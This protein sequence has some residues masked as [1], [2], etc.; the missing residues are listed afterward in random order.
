MTD[1]RP[2]FMKRVN[3]ALN[4]I[5]METTTDELNSLHDCEWAYCLAPN[6]PILKFTLKTVRKRGRKSK[7][8]TNG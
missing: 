8:K 5:I 7:E 4:L 1:D 2:D 6:H 3:K